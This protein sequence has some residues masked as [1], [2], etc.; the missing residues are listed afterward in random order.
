MRTDKSQLR[1][2]GRRLIDRQAA[3]LAEAL[4][5]LPA[6]LL[7]SGQ[8]EG[9]RCVPDLQPGIGPLGGLQSV[10][11]GLQDGRFAI[12][13][14]VDQPEMSSATLGRLTSAAR[15]DDQALAFEGHEMP[16]VLQ[17]TPGSRRVLGALCDVGCP[18]RQRSVREL[19][20]RIG[21]RRVARGPVS[22][23]EF[24]NANTPEEW[25][26]VEGRSKRDAG[27]T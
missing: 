19:L 10:I 14:P 22:E 4:G 9:Y 24:F 16:L 1:L 7:V 27:L 17:A 12:F 18:A 21:A 23:R 20:A 3:V 2:G 25:Q 15:D 26:Q 11:S 8:L 6:D 13:L 5:C